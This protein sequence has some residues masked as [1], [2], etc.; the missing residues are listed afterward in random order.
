MKKEHFQ[1]YGGLGLSIASPKKVGGGGVSGT[2]GI[3]LCA[4]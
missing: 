1:Q 4:E 3:L 2:Q